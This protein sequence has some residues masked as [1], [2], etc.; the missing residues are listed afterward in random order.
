[1][2]KIC[3]DFPNYEVCSGG[4]IYSLLS[5]KILSPATSKNGSQHVTLIKDGKRYNA[6]I[7]RLVAIAFLGDRRDLQ[8]N[9][10]DGDRKNNSLEN[11]EWVDAKENIRHARYVLKRRMGNFKLTDRQFACVRSLL[12]AGVAQRKIASFFGVTQANISRINIGLNRG[13]NR[14]TY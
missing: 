2:R 12:S 9:H 14:E 1:M 11:L 10:K 13:I 5:G 3:V 6:N 4:N 8:V 7:H